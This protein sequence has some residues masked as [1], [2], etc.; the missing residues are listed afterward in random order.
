MWFNCQNKWCPSWT[1]F[2]LHL[3]INHKSTLFLF[4]LAFFVFSS[5]HDEPIILSTFLFRL[6]SFLTSLLSLL[7]SLFNLPCSPLI[8]LYSVRSV[9]E[10]GITYTYDLNDNL[11]RKVEGTTNDNLYF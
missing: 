7:Y 2:I 8:D 3:I 5:C 11:T 10:T 9:A 4:F 1:P 6:S